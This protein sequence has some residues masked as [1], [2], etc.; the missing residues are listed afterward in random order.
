MEKEKFCIEY[1]FDKA[2]VNS[3][4]NHIATAGGLS[5]WFADEV[6]DDGNTFA[7][8]WQRNSPMGAELVGI[9][10]NVSIR[11][12]WIEEENPDVYFEFKLHK[13]ELSSGLMLAITDFAEPQEKENAISLW[14]SQIKNLARVLGL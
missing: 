5:E 12:H 10:P 1:I 9:V 2:S 8:I 14:N 11:F 13:N 6:I 3:L 4:W 7:F